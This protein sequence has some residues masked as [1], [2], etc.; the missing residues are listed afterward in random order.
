VAYQLEQAIIGLSE[1][2][3][4]LGTPVISGNASLYNETPTGQVLPTPSIG[5]VGVLDDVTSRLTVAP[6]EGDTLVLLGAAAAQPAST[7][8]GSEYQALFHGTLAGRPA[9]D[10]DLEARVQGLVLAAH[11]RAMLTAAH[12]LSDG[13][14]A[15][16]VAEMCIAAGVGIDARGFDPG[17]RRD[18]SLFGEAQ[19]RFLVATRDPEGVAVFAREAGVPATVLGRVSGDRLRLGPI[20]IALADARREYDEGL[21]RIL[22]QV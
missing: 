4:A 8:A 11:G 15:V 13:G 21:P 12:D 3:R 5:M 18:A 22:A 20:D 6:S 19:S 14:L 9:I 2:A 17:A 10:L 7:L 16:A 1:A